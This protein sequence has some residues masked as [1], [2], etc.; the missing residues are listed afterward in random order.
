MS[1]SETLFEYC[2]S[3]HHPNDPDVQ[4]QVVTADLL[5]EAVDYYL[6]NLSAHERSRL[7]S[8]YMYE[9][10][11]AKIKQYGGMQFAQEIVAEYVRDHE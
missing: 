2:T 3:F 6:E 10:C 7:L 8:A 9:D 1:R 4:T 5:E 11:Y